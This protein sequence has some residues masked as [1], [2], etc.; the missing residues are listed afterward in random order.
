MAEI[1]KITD[2]TSKEVFDGNEAVPMTSN[3]AP[4]KATLSALKDYFHD[5]SLVIFDEVDNAEN[6][7]IGD[8]ALSPESGAVFAVV[9]LTQKKQFV[10]RKQLGG[11]TL[12]SSVFSANTDYMADGAVRGDKVFFC[13]ADKELYVYIGILKNLF[14]TVRIN[15]M[16]EE[17]F[18][19]LKNPVEGAFYATYE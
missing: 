12:Y 5:S 9:Y 1:V 13:V 19:E 17:E 16:T 11:T 18:A 10:H 8:A 6:P 4:R 7:T 15:A 3:G 14:D 2:L